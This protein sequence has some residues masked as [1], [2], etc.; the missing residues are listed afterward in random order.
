ML[1][2][3]THI[4]PPNLA[5]A[6]YHV[7]FSVPSNLESYFIMPFDLLVPATPPTP[8]EKAIYLLLS[9]LLAGAYRTEE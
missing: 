6:R 3:R 5:S 7:F 8:P 1:R 4:N 2:S 9:G